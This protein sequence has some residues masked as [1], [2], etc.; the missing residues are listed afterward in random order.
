MKDNRFSTPEWEAL[1]VEIQD[2]LQGLAHDLGSMAPSVRPR[3]GKTMTDVIAL[4]SYVS[5]QRPRVDEGEYI[6]VGVDVIPQGTQWRIDADIGDEEDGTIY[7]E[8][9]NEPFS[10]SSFAEL[11]ER[12][13][14]ATDELISGGRP[15][16][17]RLFGATMP[18]ATRSGA[19]T[20]EL[21]PRN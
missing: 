21:A 2:R 13:L 20:P 10:V 12:V 16:L 18:P 8:L 7:F 17:L 9:P 5:F 11:R 15:V 1:H 6:I 4:F 19:V 3:F 14:R